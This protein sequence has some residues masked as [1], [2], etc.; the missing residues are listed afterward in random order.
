MI[1]S[2]EVEHAVDK[3]KAQVLGR[4]LAMEFCVTHYLSYAEHELSRLLRV[5]ERKDVC[6]GVLLSVLSV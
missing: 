2:S 4:R 1:V 3:E 6:G 5:G